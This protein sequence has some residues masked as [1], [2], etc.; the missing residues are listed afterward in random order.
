[1]RALPGWDFLSFPRPHVVGP[2]LENSIHP[3][4]QFPYVPLKSALLSLAVCA[5]VGPRPPG[6]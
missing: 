1:M 3:Q 2:L 6:V 5:C 4:A